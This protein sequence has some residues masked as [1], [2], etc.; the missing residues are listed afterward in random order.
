[1]RVEGAVTTLNAT[2]RLV[3]VPVPIGRHNRGPNGSP[4]GSSSGEGSLRV[5]CEQALRAAVRR[6]PPGTRL[7]PDP[8]AGRRTQR[9]ARRGRRG[10]RA[11]RRR[12]L[13]ADAAGRRDVRR[14]GDRGLGTRQT[15]DRVLLLATARV[16][17]RR[18]RAEIRPAPRAARARRRVPAGVGARASRA[19]RTTPDARLGYPDPRGEPELRE[20][21]A[22]SLARRR[23]VQASADEVVV[24]GGLGPSLPF[25]WRLL[26]ARG[27]TPRR[28]RGP[29]LAAADRDADPRRPGAG[30]DAASTS[31]A[32][33]RTSWAT[34]ARCS[35][36]P[37]TSTRPA[38]SSPPPAARR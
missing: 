6:L 29:V 18:A 9:L 14:A 22:A 34:S 19:L 32:C 17:T 4:S 25:V 30:A 7:P 36:R 21:L 35:S 16:A 3:L 26:A 37:R 23:G 11:A 13:P 10:I 12:G 33:A 8:R 24:T 31:T 38:R 1:M 20:A 15:P 27:V 2:G 5:R 28:D